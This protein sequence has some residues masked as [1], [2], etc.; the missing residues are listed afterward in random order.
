M[1]HRTGPLTATP[2]PA[3][4]LGI[5]SQVGRLGNEIEQLE[6]SVNHLGDRLM[7]ALQPDSPPA[8]TGA[9]VKRTE[10]V[11]VSPLENDLYALQ[12]RI[13]ALQSIVQNYIG[14]LEI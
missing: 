7:P 4:E 3:R 13:R 5:P 14:R 8:H 11:P 10:R 2:Q 1:D 6:M 9:E 12:A